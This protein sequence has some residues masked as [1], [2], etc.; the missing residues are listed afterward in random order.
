MPD[1]LWKT[2]TS[3]SDSPW[4][5][6]SRPIGRPRARLFCL[7][8]AGGAP[9]LFH[10]WPAD[11]P[12]DIEVVGIQL[13]GHGRRYSEPPL[14]NM[15]ALL[16]GLM[17][18]LLSATDIPFAFF[19]HSMGALIACEAAARLEGLGRYAGHLCVSACRPPH[20]PVTPTP[21]HALPR[22]AFV[23]RL[24]GIGGIP[25]ELL[26]LPDFLDA[27]LPVL[28]ADFTLIETWRGSE[29]TRLSCPM[30]AFCGDADPLVPAEQMR[31][32]SR[33]T[34]GPFSFHSF[35]GGHFYLRENQAAL[36]A[37]ISREVAAIRADVYN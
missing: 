23:E 17:P 18:A 37:R 20:M 2:R 35:R 3:L 15:D 36:L 14:D 27:F 33:H 32:W 34:Q 5:V 28:R 9:T 21:M 30:T 19:G 25:D 10:T 8:H 6:T 13:P 31:A 26:N 29:T 1:T 4:F 16:D 12:D 11:L 22:S 7:A 24:R